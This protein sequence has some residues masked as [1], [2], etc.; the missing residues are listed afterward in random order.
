[1]NEKEEKA[2]EQAVN[3]QERSV[4]HEEEVLQEWQ[5]KK[6]GQIHLQQ[7]Y[8]RG[9]LGWIQGKQTVFQAWST[10]DM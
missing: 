8:K 4:G 3:D 10:I 7:G 2:T 5:S 6:P 9:K 1:M